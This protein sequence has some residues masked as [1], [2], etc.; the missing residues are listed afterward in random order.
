MKIDSLDSGDPWGV[1]VLLAGPDKYTGGKFVEAGFALGRG[2]DV[3]VV[4]RIEN[5]MLHHP[6]VTNVADVESLITYLEV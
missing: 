6:S 1:L 5:G 2:F 4:G 3:V